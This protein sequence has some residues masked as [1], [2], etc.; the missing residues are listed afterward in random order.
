MNAERPSSHL[1]V[2]SE[3]YRRLEHIEKSLFLNYVCKCQKHIVLLK[4]STF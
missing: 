1:E 3:M 2:L 4:L